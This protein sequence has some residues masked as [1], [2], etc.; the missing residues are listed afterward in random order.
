MTSSAGPHIRLYP[1]SPSH[2]SQAQHSWIPRRS[3]RP[4]AHGLARRGLLEDPKTRN[5]LPSC[6]HVHPYPSMACRLWETRR[7][8][9][10]ERGERRRMHVSLHIFPS[11]LTPRTDMIIDNDPL[12]ERHI[13]V[14]RD[15]STLSCSSFTAGIVEAVLDGLGFVSVLGFLQASFSSPTA[16]QSDRAQHTYPTVSIP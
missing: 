5:T 9:R 8:H 11:S 15:L 2:H 16:R 6:A 14:P 4:R 7:R 1:L 13:S 10:E 12:I 3:T